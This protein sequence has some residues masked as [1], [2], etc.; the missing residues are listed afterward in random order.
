[1]DCGNPSKYNLV[2]DKEN[3]RQI[4]KTFILPALSHMSSLEHTRD[5]YHARLLLKQCAAKVYAA[6]H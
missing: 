3:K 6:L 1:M 4:K 5:S 2:Y